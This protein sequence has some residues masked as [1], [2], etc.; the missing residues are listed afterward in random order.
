MVKDKINFKEVFKTWEPPLKKRLLE[1]NY[2]ERLLTVTND[3]YKQEVV[4]PAKLDIFR[5]FKLTSYEDT[6]V[7]I[8]GQDPYPSKKATGLAFGN[9]EKD[10]QFRLSPSLQ[11]IADC[12]ERDFH[13]GINLN[14]DPTLVSWGKQG[15]LLLNSALTVEQGKVGSH[16]M[17]WKRFIREVFRMLCRNK[18]GTIF[19]LLG[20]QAKEFRMFI[21]EKQCHVLSYVHPAWS[22][23]QGT[24]W[25][26]PH[27]KKINE[28]IES[29][30]GKEY[31]IKW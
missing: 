27:F 23:R 30:N 8:L 19:L 15:V 13:E 20:A 6:R 1:T 11:L 12:V 18:P 25:N 4:R 7:V 29:Q 17:R 5:A 31:C 28:I 22:A 14:F 26:C 21:D 2:M 16:T 9:E 24:D 10:A 3:S